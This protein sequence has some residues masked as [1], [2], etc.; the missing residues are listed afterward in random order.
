MK[1]SALRR[2]SKKKTKRVR[3]RSRYAERPRFVDYM[4]AVKSLPCAAIIIPGHVC[5]G[6]MHAHHVGPSGA[7]MKSHDSLVVPLC[8]DGH[9]DLHAFRNAFRDW[10]KAKRRDFE[11]DRVMHTQR[12]MVAHN[13]APPPI[14]DRAYA[15]EIARWLNLRGTSEP[16]NLIPPRHLL[17]SHIP[18]LA[19]D[20]R[21]V[22]NL[23]VRYPDAAPLP[24]ARVVS[25]G[26][27]R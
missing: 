24:V 20:L 5:G 3:S 4:L 19:E 11:I 7:G 23:D 6:E 10:T 18:T 16:T 27:H 15:V 2:R 26:D 14:E 25:E 9:A 22:G 13:I 21:E 17:T 1:R 8:K 12:Y